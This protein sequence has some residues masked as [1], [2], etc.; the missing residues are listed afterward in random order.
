M[1]FA[2]HPTLSLPIVFSFFL[3]LAFS[4]FLSCFFTFVD[5]ASSFM[6]FYFLA[7]SCFF[8][9]VLVFSSRSFFSCLFSFFLWPC[10]T[11]KKAFLQDEPGLYVS[12]FFWFLS[13]VSMFLDSLFFLVPS[14]CL[15]CSLCLG[16]SFSP[17]FHLSC[18]LVFALFLSF[19][20]FLFLLY[21]F[22]SFILSFLLSFNKHKLLGNNFGRQTCSYIMFNRTQ[23]F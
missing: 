21:F 16:F 9:S 15:S 5:V 14:F 17:F 7:C 13:P 1:S 4:F 8:L 19:S 23:F 2:T 20:F 3:S 10:K 22:L 11:L 12:S 18:L 6:L